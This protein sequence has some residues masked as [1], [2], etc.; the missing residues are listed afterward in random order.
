[1]KHDGVVSKV[2][3]MVDMGGANSR[4]STVWK[5][6]GLRR[7]RAG[8]QIFALEQR[9]NCSVTALA[10]RKREMVGLIGASAV[11]SL[12]SSSRLPH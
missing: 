7:C 11:P 8:M 3:R 10:G 1:V 9:C 4:G 5:A 12:S 6:G 2:V